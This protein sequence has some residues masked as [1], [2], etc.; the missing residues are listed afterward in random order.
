MF[1]LINK[2]GFQMM[3]PNGIAISVML[4]E[5]NDCQFRNICAPALMKRSR[6]DVNLNASR[7]EVV[8]YYSE[9]HDSANAEI[10]IFHG[11][12]LHERAE[13]ESDSPSLVRRDDDFI[14]PTGHKTKGWVTPEELAEILALIARPDVYLEDG[15]LYRKLKAEIRVTLDEDDLTLQIEQLDTDYDKDIRKEEW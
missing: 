1:R 15:K 13:D 14:F 7:S 6:Y 2:Q 3:F 10:N 12:D 8:E 9:F 11:E 5:G 4:G